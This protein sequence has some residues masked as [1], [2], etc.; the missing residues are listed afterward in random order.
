M[1]DDNSASAPVPDVIDQAA[2]LA[3]ASALWAVRRQRPIVVQATQASHDAL[4]FD[5]VQGLSVADRLRVALACC[6]AARAGA[7]AGH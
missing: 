4:L 2:G 6:E 1:S 7:L 5:P 3:A